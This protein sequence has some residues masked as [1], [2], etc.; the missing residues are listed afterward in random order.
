LLLWRENQRV[1][2]NELLPGDFFLQV[3]SV[4]R[5]RARGERVMATIDREELRVGGTSEYQRE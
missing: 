2:R 5:E 4:E 1:E 3:C